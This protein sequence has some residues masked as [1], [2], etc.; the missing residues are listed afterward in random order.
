MDTLA[1]AVLAYREGEQPTWIVGEP[2]WI[3]ICGKKI[4]K[5]QTDVLY[6][7]IHKEEVTQYWERKKHWT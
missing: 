4:I 3:L 2:W 1:K 7:H 6:K 5:N